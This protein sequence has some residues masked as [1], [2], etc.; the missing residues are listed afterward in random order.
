M[1]WWSWRSACCSEIWTSWSCLSWRSSGCFACLPNPIETG[2]RPMRVYAAV[3]PERS[4]P[5]RWCGHL[6]HDGSNRRPVGTTRQRWDAPRARCCSES[7]PSLS[8]AVWS[9]CPSR[10]VGLSVLARPDWCQPHC[11]QWDSS[12][13]WP[14]KQLRWVNSS[15]VKSCNHGNN[16]RIWPFLGSLCSAHWA[17]GLPGALWLWAGDRPYPSMLCRIVSRSQGLHMSS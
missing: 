16:L 8:W 2:T 11:W 10:Q 12:F 17:H 14:S 13:E 1:R 3:V 9:S 6:W 7:F 5:W 4:C 15:R